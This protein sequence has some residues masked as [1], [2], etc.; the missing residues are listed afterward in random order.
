MEN[1]LDFLDH[2]IG[3]EDK[4]LAVKPRVSNTIGSAVTILNAALQGNL[5][6]TERAVIT[7]CAAIATKAQSLV[8]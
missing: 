4:A 5:G 1:F 8:G 3:L 6:N 7:R 2:V